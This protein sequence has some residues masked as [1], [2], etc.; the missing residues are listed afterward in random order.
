MSQRQKLS[1]SDA[2][3]GPAVK[4]MNPTI[5]GERKMSAVHASR[6]SRPVIV[7]HRAR[8]IDASNDTVPIDEAAS[9]HP[10]AE[11]LVHFA[12]ERAAALFDIPAALEGIFQLI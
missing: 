4:T 7:N 1:T 9:E 6:F 2:I 12:R 11:Q 10:R 8:E 5:H 3:I